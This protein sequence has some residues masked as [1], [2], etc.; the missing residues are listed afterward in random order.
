MQKLILGSI[1]FNSFIASAR[2][3]VTA[4]QAPHFKRDVDKLQ[5]DQQGLYLKM[6][7]D[8][9]STHSLHGEGGGAGLVQAGYKLVKGQFKRSL[10]LFK[11]QL[12]KLWS[13]ILLRSTT[14]CAKP[15]ALATNCGLGGS[16]WTFGETSS[17]KSEQVAH[18]G[19]GIH[20]TD[21]FKIQRG[22]A[23]AYLIQFWQES[24][25][26]E[27]IGLDDLQELLLTS[28][29]VILMGP[30][31]QCSQDFQLPK[32]SFIF[33]LPPFLGSNS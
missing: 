32:Y 9:Q 33:L 5:R 7:R 12:Q 14:R 19:Y 25:Y 13:Q 18:R 20:H 15:R 1:L 16:G 27:E 10:Q 22:Q 23:I 8:L 2:L 31:S 4:F 28:I 24:N 30:S 3:W 6:V 17:L 26:G 11:G 21:V 29:S